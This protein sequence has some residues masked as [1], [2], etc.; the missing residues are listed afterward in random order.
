MDLLLV[1]DVMLGRL[2]NQKL[3]HESP[4][5]PWGD[6]LSLFSTADVRMCNLECVI[7]DRGRPWSAT[8]KM[9][10]FRSDA[11][12]VAVLKTAAIDVVSI[13]NNHVLDF[14]YDA[15]FEMLTLLDQAR[16]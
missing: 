14:E 11:K 6:T 13:A 10:H 1:G 9:F 12:N 4:E 7:S 15:M 5:Y 16:I 3:K 8:P 2:V